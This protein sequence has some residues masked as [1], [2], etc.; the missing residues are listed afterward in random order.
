LRLPFLPV[1]AGLSAPE[2]GGRLIV[3]GKDS[4][5]TAVV[6]G[7]TSVSGR[8]LLIHLSSAIT[9]SGSPLVRASDGALGGLGS[10]RHY[11]GIAEEVAGVAR[12]VALLSEEILDIIE[13]RGGAVWR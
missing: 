2:A 1:A 4:N 7:G 8:P 9:D 6:E 12:P 3:A 10:R 5:Q 11:A 13:A